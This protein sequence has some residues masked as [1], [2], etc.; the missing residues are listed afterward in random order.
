MQL[1]PAPDGRDVR[2]GCVGPP[3]PGRCRGSRR[4]TPGTPGTR[5]W[6]AAR[7]MRPTRGPRRARP[8]ARRRREGG[9]WPRDYPRWWSCFR[10]PGGRG[11]LGPMGGVTFNEKLEGWIGARE[12]D[13]NQ[14]VVTG[15]R[16]DTRLVLQLEMDVPDVDAVVRDTGAPAT[17][18][19]FVSSPL[20]GGRCEVLEGSTF[21]LLQPRSRAPQ[22][23][24]ALPPVR[25]RRRRRA[26]HRQRLQ[27]RLRRSRLGRLDRHDLAAHPPPARAPRQGCRGPR[28]PR[29]GAR[30]GHRRD[31]APGVPAAHGRDEGR[32]GRPAA[33][34]PGLLRDAVGHLQ[35][36]RG[37]HPGRLRRP[38]ARR[39]RGARVVRAAARARRARRD[40][41]RSVPATASRS[42]SATSAATPSRPAARSWS[43]RAPGCAARSSPARRSR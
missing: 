3:A 4:S 38:D 23:P 18:R 33:L 14:G 24:D 28:G 37:E 1:Q 16:D 43:S 19:G 35:R 34:R 7:R 27:G 13:V 39:R 29:R 25:P 40:G 41:R 9:A 32:R 21:H 6:W 12:L 20:L 36:P 8:R 26:R 30:R 22:L 15:R 17:A 11:M 10:R 42:S 2:G 5:R 31:L